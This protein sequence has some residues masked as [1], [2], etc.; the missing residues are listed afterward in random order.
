MLNKN[1]LLR[2]SQFRFLKLWRVL[3]W[4]RYYVPAIVPF[5]THL[6][7]NIWIIEHRFNKIHLISFTITRLNPWPNSVTA[8]VDLTFTTIKVSKYYLDLLFTVYEIKGNGI[9][10][11]Y[12]VFSWNIFYSHCGMI[13]T[14][15]VEYRTRRECSY[16]RSKALQ[17][18]FWKQ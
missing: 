9:V 15:K 14:E 16:E 5:S 12:F 1:Y 10:F 18:V 6:Q 3:L 13:K 17:T 7:S 4:W 2:T 11:F 8:D